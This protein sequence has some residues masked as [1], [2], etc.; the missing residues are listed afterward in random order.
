M[1][2]FKYADNCIGIDEFGMSGTGND[3]M[4]HF[5]LTSEKIGIKICE[6]MGW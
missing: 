4:D 1:G 2:W 3:V 6:I 5:N